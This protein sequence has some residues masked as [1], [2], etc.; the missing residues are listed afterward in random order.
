MIWLYEINIYEK[1]ENIFADIKIDGFQT[2]KRIRAKVV[3]SDNK[4]NFIFSS[5]LPDNVYEIYKEGE[6]LFTF[7]KKEAEII[8]IWGEMS[9]MVLDNN[10]HGVYF[11]KIE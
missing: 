9:P 10:D 2:Q 7:E 1:S 8:T 11:R 4:L 5:Y 3:E 6:V